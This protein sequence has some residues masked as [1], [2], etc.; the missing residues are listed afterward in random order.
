VSAWGKLAKAT[1]ADQRAED[2]TRLPAT[3]RSRRQLACPGSPRNLCTEPLIIHSG[4]GPPTATPKRAHVGPSEV[5]LA[6]RNWH[7]FNAGASRA[8]HTNTRHHHSKS[9]TSEKM[10]GGPVEQ[11]WAAGVRN[12]CAPVGPLTQAACRAIGSRRR[13]W[14][15]GPVGVDS[16]ATV[17]RRQASHWTPRITGSGISGRGPASR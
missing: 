4:P 15:V 17:P 6:S 16:A 5:G 14:T 13:G 1:P 9:H 2:P 11:D 7:L 8:P 12:N 3:T 10:A